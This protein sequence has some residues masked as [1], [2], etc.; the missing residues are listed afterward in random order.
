MNDNTIKEYTRR[1]SSG[2]R[3]EIIV[4]VFEIGEIYM[5]EAC[6]CFENGDEDG[7]RTG[8]LKASKCINDLLESLNYEY[9]LAFP[10]MRIYMFMNKELSVASA[11]NDVETVKKIN[12]LFV[13]MK[14]SFLEVAKQDTSAPVMQNTQPVFA[15][16]TYGRNS[17]NESL[18]G[19]QNR[20]FKV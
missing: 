7:F 17:L 9:E 8:I 4:C 12:A 6:E 18:A 19:D 20:G 5:N 16:L 2:N 1:I 3:S 14:E 13:K 11:T 15:G 10:L